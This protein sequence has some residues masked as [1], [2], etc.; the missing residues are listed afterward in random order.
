MWTLTAKFSDTTSR[1][2]LRTYGTFL[3]TAK[4]RNSGGRRSGYICI[5]N[6]K[7]K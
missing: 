2:W 3:E 1:N 6:D 5:G 7:N 4:G